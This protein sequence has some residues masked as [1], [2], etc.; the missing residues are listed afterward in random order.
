M[1]E[2]ERILFKSR[3]ST[4]GHN[5]LISDHLSMIFGTHF[6]KA[7]VFLPIECFFAIIGICLELFSAFQGF[8]FT[9][10]YTKIG[11][12]L[13]LQTSPI[14]TIPKRSLVWSFRERWLVSQLSIFICSSNNL[15]AITRFPPRRKFWIYTL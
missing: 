2:L 10:F 1:A 7:L 11:V 9:H 6:Q 15:W 13:L 4:Y 12:T 8:V 14:W 5:V 3:W